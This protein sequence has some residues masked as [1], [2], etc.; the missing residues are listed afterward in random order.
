MKLIY[1]IFNAGFMY[2]AKLDSV[3]S[4]V[5]V[6][7]LFYALSAGETLAL[8]LLER[9]HMLLLDLEFERV[10]FINSELSIGVNVGT[11]TTSFIVSLF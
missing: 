11:F 6:K 10:P 9:E 4:G 8:L 5:F 3:S 1:F 2:A 7:A